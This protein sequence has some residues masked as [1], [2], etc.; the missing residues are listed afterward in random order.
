MKEQE[1][2]HLLSNNNINADINHAFTYEEDNVKK[3]K[4]LG[5]DGLTSHVLKNAPS[6][7]L[8]SNLFN[9]CL[10][11]NLVLGFG[12]DHPIHKLAYPCLVDFLHNIHGEVDDGGACGVLF[13][14][15]SKAFDMVIHD[16]IRIKLKPLCVKESSVH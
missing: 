8:I 12:Y 16:V 5:I 2:S 10:K 15:L 6:I 13:L 14:D 3:G 1:D 11:R 4:D 9:A 7:H